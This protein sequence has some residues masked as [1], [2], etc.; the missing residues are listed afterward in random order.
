MLDVDTEPASVVAHGGASPVERKSCSN[1]GWLVVWTTHST[2][3]IIL[4]NTTATMFMYLFI[5]KL[6]IIMT[7]KGAN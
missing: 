1:T 5:I 7:A 6:E 2:D 3:S 4:A